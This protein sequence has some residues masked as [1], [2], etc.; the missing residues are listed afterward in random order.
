[1]MKKVY[2]AQNLLDVGHMS[3]LLAQS[4]IQSEMRNYYLGSGVGDL[5]VNECWPELWVDEVDASRAEQLIRELNA[6]LRN[7]D[8]PWFCS[9]CGEANE[10]Q[11]DECWRC[12]TR[13]AGRTFTP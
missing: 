2:A 3:N 13:H 8:P 1:M 9:H 12:G 5:P 6:S 10:G 7:L 4:G 11:F